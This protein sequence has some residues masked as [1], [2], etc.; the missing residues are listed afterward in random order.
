MILTLGELAVRLEK[1]KAAHYSVTPPFWPLNSQSF[2]SVFRDALTQCWPRTTDLNFNR[3][4]SFLACG[5]VI[6]RFDG[7]MPPNTEDPSE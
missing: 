1:W 2:D 4:M 3:V 7:P 5:V 6:I